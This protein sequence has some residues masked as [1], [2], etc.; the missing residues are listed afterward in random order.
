VKAALKE[1]RGSYALG[2]HL[3]LGAPTGWSPPSS[4]GSVVADLGRRDVRSPPISR[5]PVHTARH[6][7]ARG[8][9]GG[10]R[11]GRFPSSCRPSTASR[12]S[13][14]GADLVD[15]SWPR[16]VATGTSMLKEM[17]EQPAPSPT[18]SAAG[19][20]PRPECGPARCEPGRPT[21][22]RWHR[23][24]ILVACRTAFTRAD[25]RPHHD[26]KSSPASPPRSTW[27]ASSAIATRSS[28]PRPSWSRSPSRVRPPTLLGA[29]KAARAQGL[30]ILPS[31]T[32]WARRFRA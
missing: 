32:S 12:F 30:P 26:G 1:V 9:G 24:V 15:P 18:R 6:R 11:H 28:A 10:G 13:G 29:V 4:A 22:V 21:P 31:P 27:A 20:P 8:R 7:G 3:H 23:T 17:H 2:R 25:A 14:V 19:S 5:D 16:R